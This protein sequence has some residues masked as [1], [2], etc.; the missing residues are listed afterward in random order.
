ML[1]I[2]RGKWVPVKVTAIQVSYDSG[3]KPLELFHADTLKKNGLYLV[4]PYRKLATNPYYRFVVDPRIIKC[5]SDDLCE[6]EDSFRGTEAMARFTTDAARISN[7]TG[8]VDVLNI[9]LLQPRNL[10][11]YY[12]NLVIVR[13]FERNTKMVT[14]LY[15]WEQR[16]GNIMWF[17][18]EKS[19]VKGYWG[20]NI[21]YLMPPDNNNIELSYVTYALRRGR[22]VVY[23]RFRIEIKGG[24]VEAKKEV[25]IDEDNE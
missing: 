8:Y 5:G 18:E 2:L 17:S 25:N 4:Y 23:Q 3:V 14:R 7:R 20:I 15:G 9:E 13:A 10:L 11:R 1:G 12:Y 22:F 6:F 16:L 19:D 21:F 24:N